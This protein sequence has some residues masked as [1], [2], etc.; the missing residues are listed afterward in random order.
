MTCLFYETI[1]IIY[2]VV[3]GSLSTENFIYDRSILTHYAMNGPEKH[4]L[5]Y[6]RT[7]AA[8]I[9]YTPTPFRI[10]YIS[11]RGDLPFHLI[12]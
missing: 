3:G 7:G 9:N 8:G 12:P 11:N 4:R 1:S 6:M 5:S 10:D 2:N